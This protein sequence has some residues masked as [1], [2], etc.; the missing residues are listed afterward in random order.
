VTRITV[1]YGNGEAAIDPASLETDDLRWRRADVFALC[2]VALDL[3]RGP[4]LGLHWG[5]WLT[6]SSFCSLMH[7]PWTERS[8]LFTASHSS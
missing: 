6:T 7:R 2:Q 1:G 3:T 8:R 5:E 4:A